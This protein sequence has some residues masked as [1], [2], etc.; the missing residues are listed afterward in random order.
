MAQQDFELDTEELRLMFEE[1]LDFFDDII[2]ADEQGWMYATIWGI[3]RR[4]ISY[5]ALFHRGS[6]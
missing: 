2:I 4:F 3:A 6:W 1:E 5:V